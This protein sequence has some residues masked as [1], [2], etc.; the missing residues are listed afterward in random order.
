MVGVRKGTLRP[1]G[2]CD[3][4]EGTVFAYEGTT[5]AT[6]AYGQSGLIFEIMKIEN[7]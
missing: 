1:V 6:T 2:C 5:G 3:L 7:R 4:A